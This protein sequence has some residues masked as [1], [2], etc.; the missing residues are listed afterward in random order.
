[1]GSKNGNPDEE[2]VHRVRISHGF[3]I[4]KFEVT[5]AQWETVVRDPHARTDQPVNPSKFPG[6]SRPVEYVSWEDVQI[7][8]KRLNARDPGFTYRLP[9]EAEWEYACKAGSKDASLRDLDEVAWY[10]TNSES[11][12]HQIGDKEPNAW[13]LYDMLG[14]VA[15]WVQDWYS[16]PYYFVSPKADPQGPDNGSYRVFRGGSWLDGPRN[17]RAAYRGFDF[18]SSQFYNVG[19]R[20][21]RIAKV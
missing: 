7:F 11:H 6:N 14:N 19:F 12:T 2:P 16:R 5:Q 1:M 18:P 21:V 15:E 13:G 8:L 10:Q 4:G 3:E 20:L 9:T 17:C